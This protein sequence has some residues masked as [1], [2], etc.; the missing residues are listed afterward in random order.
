ML[1]TNFAEAGGF[2]KSQPEEAT[3][4]LQL[5]FVIG[6]LDQPWPQTVPWPR[7]FV[8][9]VP[10]A[11]F[12]PGQRPAGQQ[13]PDGPAAGGPELPGPPRRHGPH[14]A[15]LQADAHHP[16]ATR[17]G[18]VWRAR[19]GHLGLAQTDEQ[20]EQFI[21]NYGD[22]IYHPVGSCRMGPTDMDVVDANCAC[23]ACKACGWWTHRSCRASLAAT[24]MHR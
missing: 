8:P 19:T 10:A 15:R 7:L 18:A 4:D 6:K 5:H 13:R 17:A 16:G 2:I 20:I 14:G 24:P 3:P 11:A 22:T 12:E 21:R 23:T 9:C 1:T